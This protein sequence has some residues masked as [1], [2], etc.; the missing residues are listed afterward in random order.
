MDGLVDVTREAG[1]HT[2]EYTPPGGGGGAPGEGFGDADLQPR[3]PTPPGDPI[4]HT[5]IWPSGAI[6]AIARIDRAIER[7]S[8]GRAEMGATQNALKHTARNAGVSA[9]N[10]ARSESRIRDADIAEEVAELQRWQVLS[11]ASISMMAEAN[12]IPQM[13]LSLLE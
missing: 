4:S 10:L 7:V 8:R 6:D 2:Y 5:D 13:I 9:E 11:Q 3:P 12:K 1:S